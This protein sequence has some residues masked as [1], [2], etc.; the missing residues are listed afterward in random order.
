MYKIANFFMIC[1]Y[2]GVT[3]A[4][5][6]EDVFRFSPVVSGQNGTLMRGQTNLQNKKEDTNN[7]PYEE[8]QTVHSRVQTSS[9]WLNAKLGSSPP[10]WLRRES[11]PRSSS[12]PEVMVSLRSPTKGIKIG[13]EPDP[14]T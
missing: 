2:V 14:N 9:S 12:A 6:D 5:F 13:F 10:A 8:E 7:E 1:A 3:Q 4:S 11:K